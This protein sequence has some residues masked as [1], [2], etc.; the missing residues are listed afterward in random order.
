[1][2]AALYANPFYSISSAI[3]GS[4]SFVWHLAP[5][6]YRN[7]LMGDAV[8]APVVPWYAAAVVYACIGGIAWGIRLIRRSL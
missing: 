4:A 8:P 2:R 7:T 5:G 1:M 3:A 6:M